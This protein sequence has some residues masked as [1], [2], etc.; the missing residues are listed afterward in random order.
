MLGSTQDER[1]ASLS[2]NAATSYFP[3]QI[4][5]PNAFSR[6]SFERATVT[7]RIGLATN[8]ETKTITRI[9]R[10]APGIGTR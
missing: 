6:P 2:P 10:P 3:G 1:A 7:A 5:I 8:G 4:L 9:H